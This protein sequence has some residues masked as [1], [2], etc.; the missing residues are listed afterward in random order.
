MVY[1]GLP[2]FMLMLHGTTILYLSTTNLKDAWQRCPQETEAWRW[3]FRDFFLL[4][5]V[6]VKG[7]SLWGVMALAFM[8]ITADQALRGSEGTYPP[9]VEILTNLVAL[10][11]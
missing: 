9:V 4:A 8:T 3:I 10:G 7:A 2:Y 5:A 11:K 1:F 6:A